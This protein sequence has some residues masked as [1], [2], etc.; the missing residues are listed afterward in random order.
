M[1]DLAFQSTPLPKFSPNL[2]FFSPFLLIIIGD[3]KKG[4]N[5]RGSVQSAP[6]EPRE[7]TKNCILAS[8]T[9]SEIQSHSS[10]TDIAICVGHCTTVIKIP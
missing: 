4:G 9:R 1:I 7:N 5:V 3:R 2:R 8:R 10:D 6:G